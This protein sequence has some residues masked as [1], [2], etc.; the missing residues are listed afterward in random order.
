MVASAAALHVTGLPPF[1]ERLLKKLET[2]PFLQELQRPMWKRQCACYSWGSLNFQAGRDVSSSWASSF[3]VWGE[4]AS[5]KSYRHGTHASASLRLP[6]DEERALWLQY[7]PHENGFL[8]SQFKFTTPDNWPREWQPGEPEARIVLQ[9]KQLWKEPD[10]TT[11]AE[12]DTLPDP[13]P[14]RIEQEII[15]NF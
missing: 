2:A 15:V 12:W 1:R 10:S 13:E 9:G 3:W 8:P 14:K 11:I 7:W 6:P 4:A 5:E